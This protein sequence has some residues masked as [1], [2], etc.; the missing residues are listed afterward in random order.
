MKEGLTEIVC[1]LDRSGSMSSIIEDAIGGFNTFLGEQKKEE[2]ECN[3]TIA[4]FDNEYSLLKDN[5]SID[6]VEELNRETYSP[7]ASTALYDAI[8]RTIN[9]VGARLAGTPEDE[10]PER[11]MLVILTDGYEN[12]SREFTQ[13]KIFEMIQRQENDYNWEFIYLGANQDAMATGMGLG[14]KSASTKTFLASGDGVKDLYS[15]ISNTVSMYRKSGN[16]SLKQ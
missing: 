2:G 10:R 4:L 15:D 13:D 3:F 8:G 16:V 12:S 1:V 7:R 5:V 11:V 9:T 6:E 14:F